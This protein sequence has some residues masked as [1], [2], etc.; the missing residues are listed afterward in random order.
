[1]LTAK[2]ATAGATIEKLSLAHR[3]KISEGLKR[4]YLEGRRKR[5]YL[6]GR[7]KKQSLETRFKISE[8]MKRLYKE[9]KMKSW[10]KGKKGLQV[11]WNK[12]LTK[13]NDCRIADYGKKVSK[14]KKGCR[15]PRKGVELT[16][17]TKK[18]ISASHKGKRLSGE[19]KTKISNRLK[20]R[21]LGKRGRSNFWWGKKR[22]EISTLLKRLNCDKSFTEKRLKG[23]MRR[24]T[25]LEYKIIYLIEKYV[26]PF[27][28][29]GNGQIIIGSKN[30]DFI[31]IKNKKIIEVFGT[32]WHSGQKAHE[33]PQERIKYFLKH[34]Y[35]TLILWEN[36]LKVQNWEQIIVER[37][38][39]WN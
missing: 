39:K 23:L 34:G 5:A 15:S 12:G 17:E 10:N 22:P 31:G 21:P 4:A 24:P 16:E 20:G 38:K 28:Y 8:T 2:T 25:T 33:S 9:G 18:K 32:Y 30:P 37:I 29:V 3:S 14:I 36:E 35:S 1:M 6:G 11:A 13:E 7:R 27:K 19:H 26:L